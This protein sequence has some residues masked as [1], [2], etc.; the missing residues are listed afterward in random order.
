[1]AEVLKEEGNRLMTENKPMEAIAKLVRARGNQAL[2][3]RRSIHLPL[4]AR[5]LVSVFFM[6]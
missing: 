2:C 6:F 5:S 1:M 4:S 3:E